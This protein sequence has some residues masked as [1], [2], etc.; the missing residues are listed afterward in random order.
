[1]SQLKIRHLPITDLA[2]ICVQPYSLQ[3]HSLKQVKSGGQGP[4][5]NPTRG[6]FPGIVNRQPGVFP[7]VRDS[8]E[9][10]EKNIKAA[11]RSVEEQEM[12]IPVARQLYDYCER[13]EVQATELE[14][15]PISFSVGPK[16]LC[17]SPALFIYPD[18]VTIPFLDLRRGRNL[19]REAR[20][21]IFSLKHHALRVNN[22]D[23]EGLVTFEIFQFAKN[24]ERTIRPIA[25][26]GMWLYSYEQLEE[27][28][29]RTQ[30]LWFDVLA[31]REEE[32]RRRSGG[33]RGDL[34]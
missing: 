31:D 22:P 34:L 14:A 17:W 19:T 2:R 1:M 32:V 10:I 25:E 27:M 4:N 13:E 18:R 12:N 7:S 30:H 16:L 8:W 20:R 33:K 3:R 5:Y 9:V 6:Q 26:D 28:I 15:F 21:C 11:C 29:A 24:D 23:Y